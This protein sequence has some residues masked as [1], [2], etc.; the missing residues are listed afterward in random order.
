[1][2]NAHSKSVHNLVRMI[3]DI[4]ENLRHGASDDTIAAEK[5]ANHINCFWPRMMKSEIKIHFNA[6]GYGLNSIARNAI[7]IIRAM[8][9]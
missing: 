5:V 6:G 3:N 7:N 8:D 1:M 4:S 9:K 2:S